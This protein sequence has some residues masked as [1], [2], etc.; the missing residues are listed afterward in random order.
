MSDKNKLFYALAAA[1]LAAGTLFYLYLPEE[2]AWEKAAK[3]AVSEFSLE[4]QVVSVEENILVVKTGRVEKTEEGNKF[5]YYDQKV[6]LSGQMI[7]GVGDRA[8][9][10][11]SNVPAR[12]NFSAH[13]A[14]IIS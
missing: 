3:S 9:F 14:E 10:Y 13:R 1:V 12:E 5:V 6:T 4:G 8:I 7:P 11:G 2:L